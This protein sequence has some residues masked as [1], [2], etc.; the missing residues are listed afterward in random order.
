MNTDGRRRRKP[1]LSRQA[2]AAL[3]L[4]GK[5]MGTMPGLKPRQ[6]PKVKKIRAVKGI[7]AAIRA[8]L[9]E[10]AQLIPRIGFFSIVSSRKSA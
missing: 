8:A 6:R 5:Y 9:A 1:R 7:A 10:L 2:R 3:M 4:Q